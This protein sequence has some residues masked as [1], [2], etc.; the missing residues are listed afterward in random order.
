MSEPPDA[1]ECARILDEIAQ[2]G[3]G[4]DE[5]QLCD[6][7]GRWLPCRHCTMETQLNDSRGL[8]AQLMVRRYIEPS[9]GYTS[10]SLGPD[11]F[12]REVPLHG[13]NSWHR[14]RVYRTA[15]GFDDYDEEATY[16]EL[17]LSA[18][19]EELL[20]AQCAFIREHTKPIEPLP[21]PPN[22][23]LEQLP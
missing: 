10:H 6:S 7:C 4:P 1:V 12:P 8:L 22:P 21:L 19:D 13:P 20:R 11:Q 9:S 17:G 15:L 18:L 2:L 23:F 16:G 5:P 14:M 3:I